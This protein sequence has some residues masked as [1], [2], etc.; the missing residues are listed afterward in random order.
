MYL[1][2]FRQQ[3]ISPRVKTPSE[4]FKKYLKLIHFH[5][6]KHLVYKLCR[7]IAELLVKQTIM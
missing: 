4:K 3:V 7:E 5:L 1:R 6:E 2:P